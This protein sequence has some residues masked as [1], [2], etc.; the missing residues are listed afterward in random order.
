M[1]AGDIVSARLRGPDG[2][3]A[4]SRRPFIAG[5]DGAHSKGARD[6]RREFPGGGY[7]QTFYVADVAATG[8]AFNGDLN[9]ELDGADFLA[10]FPLADKGRVA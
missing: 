3:E 1:E 2:A 10:I 7:P 9:I 8:P 5:A 6:R 4:R